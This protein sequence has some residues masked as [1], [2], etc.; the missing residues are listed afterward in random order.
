M[1]T[2]R[3][4][5][6]HMVK[7]VSA[8]AVM[9]AAA[10][11]VA[12]ATTA[13]AASTTNPTI[14]CS[15]LG[16]SPVSTN[17]YPLT[18]GS[19]PYGAAGSTL[20]FYVF[21]SGFANNNGTPS[22][23][24]TA[25]GVQGQVTEL[26]TSEAQVVLYTSASTTPGYYPITITDTNGSATLASAF[27]VDPTGSSNGAVPNSIAVGSTRLI[28]VTGEGLSTGTASILGPT[29]GGVSG[30][31]IPT[32]SESV[33]ADGTTLTF[34]ATGSIVGTYQ[35]S[36]GVAQFTVTVTGP[37][38]T[39][40]SVASQT[41]YVDWEGGTTSETVT[42]TGSGFESG[43]SVQLGGTT[44][45]ALVDGATFS[46]PTVVNGTTLTFSATVSGNTLA[47]DQVNVTVIN[48]DG[49][50]VTANNALG[51]GTPGAAPAGAATLTVDTAP[52]S[53]L[54]AQTNLT[55]GNG[56]IVVE[57]SPGF[58]ITTGSTVTLSTGTVSFTGAVVGVD[59]S[60]GYAL[61]AYYLPAN[62]QTSLTAAVPAGVD[63]L[64]LT[65]LSGISQYTN[66][67]FTDTGDVSTVAALTPATS[68]A[69]LTT[70]TASAHPSGTVVQWPVAGG[71]G[72][73]AVP[74]TLSVNNGTATAQVA[75]MTFSQSVGG[76]LGTW[77]YMNDQGNLESLTNGFNLAPG[78]YTFFLTYPGMN[79]TTG[80]TIA[81]ADAAGSNVGGL[82]GT[83]VATGADTA[84]VR[85]TV[86]ATQSSTA[87]TEVSALQTAANPGQTWLNL[88]T[89]GNTVMPGETLVVGGDPGTLANE[90]V[91]VASTWN[92]ATWYP[93]TQQVITTGTQVG[94]TTFDILNAAGNGPYTT[95]PIVAGMVVTATTG[96]ASIGTVA[97]YDSSTGVVTLTSG[98]ATAESS[99]TSL[100]FTGPGPTAAGTS[101]P[102]PLT[103]PLTY[104]HAQG[105]IVSESAGPQVAAS[106][107]AFVTN[108]AGTTTAIPF[109]TTATSSVSIA[110]LSI[111]FQ[112]QPAP[113]VGSGPAIVEPNSGALGGYGL[114]T[115][116]I[117]GTFGETGASAASDYVVSSTTPGVTFG[118]VSSSST[119][120]DLYV[121]IIV[122]PG[123]PVNTSIEVTVTDLN[124]SGTASVPTSTSPGPYLSVG[125]QPT[126]TSVQA[127]PTLTAG[128]SA[129]ITITGT[130]FTSGMQLTFLADA[131]NLAGGPDL[132]TGLGSDFNGVNVTGVTTVSS[133]T[134][135][136][137]VQVGNGAS[138]GAHD[139]FVVNGYGGSASS[140]NVLNVSM[141]T[142][143]SV[144]PASGQSVQSPMTSYVLSGVQ[145]F[146]FTQ[147]TPQA[148]LP[149]VYYSVFDAGFLPV[150]YGHANPWYELQVPVA[151][152][153]FNGPNSLVVT[154]PATLPM[155]ANG[156]LVFTLT[157]GGAPSA[158][159]TAVAVDAPAI[160][161]NNPVAAAN[162]STALAAGTSSPFTINVG[163]SSQPVTVTSGTGAGNTVLLYPRPASVYG[164]LVDSTT[165][166]MAPVTG[167]DPTTGI[168]TL[169][170]N[171]G[172]AGTAVNINDVVTYGTTTAFLSGATVSVTDTNGTPVPGIT[173]TGV[174]VLPG[175]I[176]GNVAVAA[177]GVAHGIYD[178]VVTNPDG[179][180]AIS[181]F[182]VLPRPTVASVNG[183]AAT[184]VATGAPLSFLAGSQ[185]TLTIVGTGFQEGA[186]VSTPTAGV[187]SFGTAT[188]NGPG[189]LLTVPVTFTSFSGST[190][191]T[192]DVVITN[193]TTGGSVTIPGELVVSPGP[194]VTGTYY[195]PTFT[196]NTEV[197]INGT[198]FEQ[199]ITATSSNSDYTVSAVSSTP[200]TVTLLVSTDSNATSGTSS[201]VTLTNPDGGTVTFALN[202]GVNPNTLPKAPRAFR[203][204]GAVWTSKTAAL[205]TTVRV[206]GRYF[207]GQPQVTANAAGVKVGVSHDSGS[208][209]TL[210]VHTPK[211]TA[212]GVHVFT[213]TFAKGQT[214]TVKFN[215]RLR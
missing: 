119:A 86:P 21:G 207:Y 76:S 67:T 93:Q 159:T 197:V 97:S 34:Y 149:A 12:F 43:A 37:T 177:T 139:L 33:S 185:Q 103:A 99:G 188:V 49:T 113:T 38:I 101:A 24:T 127:L 175:L 130:G 28:T 54:G 136:A 84:T 77:Q 156:Y 161:L 202:G 144:T 210:V 151:D 206:T 7:A 88:A 199:G 116:L 180:T 186:T 64:P 118:P 74:F 214:I 178:F 14:T 5:S 96:G 105:D 90:T 114:P 163:A 25:P 15:Q 78:T 121:P 215:L 141:P 3:R 182:Q 106:Y 211:N 213:I 124:G 1:N 46:A 192:L 53:Y 94:A 193:P 83:I 13:G 125:A 168:V 107:D 135:T 174:S 19:L 138:N 41:G 9:V 143:A 30:L 195:V 140:A 189:T 173:V 166:F 200:T 162:T 58:T 146:G 44:I 72:A 170:G 85:V 65:N 117:N 171:L 148:D 110:G 147:A 194:T 196:S 61:I 47:G 6:R 59:P 203:T 11:P 100:T 184:T 50:M 8:G 190:P 68:A 201:N 208:V 35:V 63:A 39:G 129:P 104:A 112:G 66:L 98:A 205:V 80:S 172:P 179:S 158:A 31:T 212:R 108:A 145:G 165:G 17:P 157:S 134:I 69:V 27:G 181:T 91:T 71:G 23:T 152:V 142:V 29:N 176:T 128:E 62:L 131:G 2:L 32:A 133:T 92:P 111:L 40:V 56:Y 183:Q 60:N 164:M 73:P 51:I 26:S 126:I 102:I 36:I 150:G 16:S 123:T 55:T 75:G 115:L 198:G 167:Y 4:I 81:F 120:T 154:I 48:P 20:V 209:L 52:E 95:Y 82:T 204:V 132:G 57:P 22:V 45:P 70:P 155:E 191:V 42:V 122:A 169:G 18:C 160:A 109:A 187:A 10:L 137:T 89:S 87:L 79:L 153:T